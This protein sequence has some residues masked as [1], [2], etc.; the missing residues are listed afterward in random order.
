MQREINLLKKHPQQRKGIAM[1][2]AIAFLIITAVMMVIMVKMTAATSKK[3]GDL[4]F[5]EQAHLLAKSATEYALLAIS[6]HE[7]SA[8][9]ECLSN[10]NIQ[11]PSAGATAI[12]DINVSINY[13]GVGAYG[14]TCAGYINNITTIAV[15]LFV[16]IVL[17]RFFSWSVVQFFL[18]CKQ[19][20]KNCF[21]KK[22]FIT[23]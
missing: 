15:M 9:N 17:I 12:Y 3:T 21:F 10:I 19:I 7:R 8:A 1:L 23:L 22:H 18:K 11:Y 20:K 2:I 5:Q 4:F 16:I 13:I 6:G 14:G